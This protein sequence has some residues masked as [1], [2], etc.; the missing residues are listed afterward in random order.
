MEAS[1]ALSSSTSHQVTQLFDSLGRLSQTQDNSA[2]SY[3]DTAYNVLGQVQSLSKPYFS[4]SDSTYGVTTY[5][6]EALGRVNSVQ[7]PGGSTTSINFTGNSATYCSTVT[8]PANKVRKLC[9][10]ALGRVTSVTEDP[11]GLNYQTSYT[12]DALNDLTGVT[13]GSQTR[14]YNY[15]MLA[16]LTSAQTP[17][18]GTTSYSYAV[19]G[20]PCSGDPSAPCSRT[21]ARGI[22]TAYTCDSLNR[23]ASKTYSDGTPPASFS[24]DQSSVTIGSWKSGTLA[25]PNGR[26]TEATTTASGSV[27]TAVV[28]SYDPVGRTQYFWQCNPSNCG[29]SSIWST[30]YSYDLA[31][32][33]TSWVHPAGYK[34]TNTVNAAQQVTAVQS[35]WQDSSHPQYLAQ[36]VSYT[37]WGAVSQLE[38]GCVGTGCAKAQETYTYNKQLQPSMIQLTGTS[39]GGYCLVYNYYWDES[40]ATSCAAPTQGKQNNGDV[41]GYWYSDAVNSSFGHTA[42]YTYDGVNR[43]STAVATGNSTCNLTF[44]Y[45]RYA[46]LTTINVTQCTAP[47]LS[48]SLNTNNQITNPGFTYDADGDLTAD[49]TYTYSWN[50]DAHLNSAASVTYTY[51]GD[52]RRVEKSNGTLYWYCAVCGQVLAESDLS[53]NLTSEYTFFN[54]K[55]IARRDVSWGNVYYLFHDRLGSYRTVTDSSGN[56]KGESDYY[57]FGGERVISSAVTDSFRFAGMEWDSETSQNR[58]QYRQYTSAQGRWETPDPTRGCVNFPQGQNLYAYVKDNPTNL[59]DLLGDDPISG[60]CGGTRWEGNAACSG[61]GEYG[62]GGGG[63]GGGGGGDGDGSA[64]VT[65]T[66]YYALGFGYVG[67]GCW[68]DCGCSDGSTAIHWLKCPVYTVNASDA[69]PDQATWNGFGMDYDCGPVIPPPTNNP[70][71]PRPPLPPGPPPPLPG[72]EP[73]P[74]P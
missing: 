26:L 7:A 70:K 73:V 47:M 28:F 31:G 52:L 8:D 62:S 40:N 68:Y 34:L 39:N 42:T 59:I 66:C 38:N 3:V 51:D 55:R 71:G 61:P 1:T 63:G 56:V 74:I 21:D 67:Q 22:S 50:A 60:D 20:N 33:V 27:N 69:C 37:P 12:Y 53:G 30:Q 15:D 19:S 44:G 54:R 64:L 29:G 9:S 65:C 45:D 5:G 57:A 58:T 35:S 18:A 13:Q 32:D 17:E 2:S 6:Y 24:Y 11:S 72:W 48:L 14:T 23:L 25:N 41:M 16:R 10:D 49:G 43:L 46:N 4:K 36:S